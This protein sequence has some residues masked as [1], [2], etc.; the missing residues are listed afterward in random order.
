MIIDMQDI[1]KKYL[2]NK[3]DEK[4]MEKIETILENILSLD[5]HFLKIDV[6]D[7]KKIRDLEKEFLSKI[8]KL[9]LDNIINT[10]STRLDYFDEI[11]AKIMICDEEIENRIKKDKDKY[12]I[13]IE[14]ASK[15][16]FTESL[17]I[18]ENL[19]DAKIYIQ[20]GMH[21]LKKNKYDTM[22]GLALFPIGS[23][24]SQTA[25]Q[26]KTAFLDRNNFGVCIVDSDK[27]SKTHNYGNTA[28][29]VLKYEEKK[30]NLGEVIVLEVREL[31]NLISMSIYEK[32]DNG[33][34]E[35]NFFK[36]FDI[37]KEV[38]LEFYK[39]ADLKNGLSI[40]ELKKNNFMSK[41]KEIFLNLNIEK[42]N[43]SSKN[44]IFS[45]LEKLEEILK[46][47]IGKDLE[48]I[49]KLEEREEKIKNEI[50]K[51]KE[52]INNEIKEKIEKIEE[53]ITR[54]DINTLEEIINETKEEELEKVNY[55]VFRGNK[56]IAEKYLNYLS[57]EE[58]NNIK[59]S[60]ET[61]KRIK[62]NPEIIEKEEEKILFYKD[63][64][65]DIFLNTEIEKIAT[66]IIEWGCCIELRN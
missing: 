47:K 50:E 58:I 8:S 63:S 16:S 17:V 25:E 1:I 32:L 59:K 65:K 29:D 30:R 38:V 66:K 13:T 4:T 6:K 18:A 62:E 64:Y 55:F 9:K 19:I 10:N 12:L 28:N 7:Y 39:Y 34:T 33:N 26:Y 49:E 27:K 11:N 14:E 2:D 35:C 44:P 15:Y 56:K 3:Y 20:Y 40:K 51:I 22:V 5:Y 31:E 46:I 60:I 57:G 24:G 52:I 23:G 43:K 61:K 41:W 37:S 21:Y 53:A 42:L 54:K 45:S 48:N 36:A